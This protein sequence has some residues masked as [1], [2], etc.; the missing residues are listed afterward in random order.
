MAFT[1]ADLK[2]LVQLRNTT[3]QQVAENSFGFHVT[4]APAVGENWEDLV[5]NFISYVQTAYL[6][7]INNQW[8]IEQYKIVDMFSGTVVGEIGGNI[9]Y[10]GLGS[11]DAMPPQIA[12]IVSWRSGR[13]GRR[14]KGRTY[15]PPTSEGNSASA[16]AP[17]GPYIDAMDQWAEL[18]KTFH[19][20]IG[21]EGGVY[22]FSIMSDADQSHHVVIGHVSRQKWA[23]RRSRAN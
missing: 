14:G 11:G 15:L 20:E 5:P 23:T 8:F 21:P 19:T 22:T 16:G 7:L 4:T 17:S 12:G 1:T 18:M 13:T 3:I 9:N 2:L 6:G 10:V